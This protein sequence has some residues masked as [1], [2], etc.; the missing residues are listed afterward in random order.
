MDDPLRL[1]QLWVKSNSCVVKMLVKS[2]SIK[3]VTACLPGSMDKCICHHKALWVHYFLRI[4]EQKRGAFHGQKSRPSASHFCSNQIESFEGLLLKRFIFSTWM[5]V[6]VI[7]FCLLILNQVTEAREIRI[8]PVANGISP[9]CVG[10]NDSA[11]DLVRGAAGFPLLTGPDAGVTP[12][13]GDTLVLAPGIYF[14][15]VKAGGPG[16]ASDG[17]GPLVIPGTI[18][19][20]A[21]A[22]AVNCFGSVMQGLEI[23]SRDGANVTVIDAT[24]LAGGLAPAV[25]IGANNVSFGGDSA[26]HGLTVQNSPRTGIHIGTPVAALNPYGIDL[27]PGTQ[28]RE[29]IT[30][31]NNFIQNNDPLLVLA[32]SSGVHVDY[33]PPSVAKSVENLRIHNNIMRDNGL[34]ILI[35]RPF[36]FP[37]GPGFGVTNLGG[38][39]EDEGVFITNNTIDDNFSHGIN[40]S[41]VGTQEQIV[42]Q[43][44]YIVR[45]GDDGISWTAVVTNIENILI[46]GNMIRENG[47]GFVLTPPFLIGCVPVCGGISFGNSGQIEDVKIVDNRDPDFEE[48]ITGNAG[49]GIAFISVA[50]FPQLFFPGATGVQDIDG[51]VIS[52][53]VI[54]ANGNPAAVAF[55]AAGL[56]RFVPRVPFDGITFLNNGD[57][58]NLLMYG[59][60]VRLNAGSGVTFGLPG[61]GAGLPGATYA[62]FALPGD[63]DNNVIEHNEFLNNGTGGTVPGGPFFPHGDGFAVFSQNDINDNLFDGNM[64]IENYN[65]G[66]FLSSTG[67][68]ITSI[69]FLSNYLNKN[70]LG[71]RGA[72]AGFPPSDGLELSTFGD[73]S[74]VIWDGGQASDNGGSGIHFDANNNTLSNGAYGFGGGVPPANAANVRITLADIDNILIQNAMF[75][76]NGASA[77]TG[78]GNGILGIS[79]KLSGWQTFNIEANR[80]DDH[81]QLLT[82]TDDMNDIQVSDSQFNRNDRNRDSVGSGLFFDTTEDMN[83]I[84][85][86]NVIANENHTGIR[87]D[88]KGENGRSLSVKDSVANSNNESGIFADGSDDLSDV[89]LINNVLKYNNTGITLRSTDHGDRLLIDGNKIVG[90]NGSGI[91]IQLQAIGVAVLNNSIRDNGVGIAAH[92]AQDSTINCNNISHNEDFGVDAQGLKPGEKLDVTGNWWGEASGP[93]AA[94]NVNGL[95]DR[96]TAKVDFEPWQ[97]EPCVETDVNFQI[98]QFEVSPNP[99]NLG[100]SATITATVRNNGTEEGSQKISLKIGDGTFI[101]QN[102]ETRT[103]NP[104][105]EVELSFT[106]R[107]PRGGSFEIT[108]STAQD[109]QTQTIEVLGATGV[110]IE[111]V[112]DANDNSRID[113]DEIITCVGYWVRSEMVPGTGQLISD[114]KIS[115]LIEL[116][117]TN[118]D[119]STLSVETTDIIFKGMTKNTLKLETVSVAELSVNDSQDLSIQ[120]YQARPAMFNQLQI[121]MNTSSVSNHRYWRIGPAVDSNPEMFDQVQIEME[122]GSNT[123]NNQWWRS[124]G[125]SSSEPEMIEGS[126]IE[127]IGCPD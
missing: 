6:A 60:N 100:E 45:N 63:F 61:N 30:I 124:G 54:N 52:N 55:P 76:R 91:G 82:T 10:A 41:N 120:P 116:W 2:D 108:L 117:A 42:V 44:N 85:V 119:I 51:L 38:N 69:R 26:G 15:Q 123:S 16:P 29:D 68:D 83:N 8:L 101:E 97:S 93:D 73:I 66:M 94:T 95:G 25:I 47:H 32:I 35:G 77:P 58:E 70:G 21:C 118:G 40:F 98:T 87:F 5:A 75:L 36:G 4:M 106:I 88:V 18:G 102:T 110:S 78:S 112:C 1:N 13:P 20:G 34:G 67:N 65:H 50:A 3:V 113:D 64:S 27:S 92:R 9:L 56:D 71:N 59:N 37:L 31:Q 122:G 103:L 90:E 81:G 49:P 17:T 62:G 53:N 84:S 115:F 14:L 57:V 72:L 126:L 48:G 104:A 79:D 43:N 24:A 114:E 11:C 22:G 99:V 12:Q 33:F 111:S 89:L 125:C 46:K 19:A 105:T 7:G 74:D 39:S 23:R 121:E 109:T 80:N 86:S 107:F 96:V 28:G 127:Q